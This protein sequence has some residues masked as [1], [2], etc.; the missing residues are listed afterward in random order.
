MFVKWNSNIKYPEAT[1]FLKRASFTGPSVLSVHYT[2][3][4]KERQFQINWHGLKLCELLK[5]SKIPCFY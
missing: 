4:K 3:V 2:Q 1:W 5:K